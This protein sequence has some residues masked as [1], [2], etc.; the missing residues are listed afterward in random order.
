MQTSIFMLVVMMTV[1]LVARSATAE[2]PPGM[3]KAT[4]VVH[5]NDVGVSAL[6]GKPGVISVQRGWSGV[7]EIDRVVYDPQVVSLIELENWLKETGTYISTMEHIISDI[8]AK[9]EIK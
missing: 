3:A 8:P 4:F 7:R 1:L 6:Q 9:E 2:V 5:C